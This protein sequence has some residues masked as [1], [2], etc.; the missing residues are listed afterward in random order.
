MVIN[1]VNTFLG[2]PGRD[3]RKEIPVVEPQ[4][5]FVN[6]YLPH[7]ELHLTYLL[8]IVHHISQTKVY[9]SMH[10]QGWNNGFYS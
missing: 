5:I 2:T 4:N 3:W 1:T 10:V 8:F 6:F 7:A 9:S